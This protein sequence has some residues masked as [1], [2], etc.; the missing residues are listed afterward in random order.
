M[1]T[2]KELEE[3]LDEAKIAHIRL[4]QKRHEEI[5]EKRQPFLDKAESAKRTVIDNYAVSL[6]EAVQKKESARKAL[7]DARVAAAQAGNGAPYPIGTKL[8]EW[9]SPKWER[10]QRPTGKAGV[11]EVFTVGSPVPDGDRWN[12]P[13]PGDYALRHL[14]KDGTPGKRVEGWSDWLSR[15]WRTE[16]GESK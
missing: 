11:I 3:K 1:S 8:Y 13:E 14:K 4:E 7:D 5:E 10:T 9:K 6:A 15:T 16:A 2:I 12:L